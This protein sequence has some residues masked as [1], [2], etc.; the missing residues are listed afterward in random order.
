MDYKELDNFVKKSNSDYAGFEYLT[1]FFTLKLFDSVI[2]KDIYEQYLNSNFSIDSEKRNSLLELLEKP[3]VQDY[4]LSIGR[5]DLLII[6]RDY[7]SFYNIDKNL[8]KIVYY[9]VL[10]I[11]KVPSIYN[12]FSPFITGEF[13]IVSNQI[14]TLC[15]KLVNTKDKSIYVPFR[16]GLSVADYMNG[17]IY[18]EDLDKRMKIVELFMN[19]YEQKKIQ[20]HITNSLETPT[21]IRKNELIKF[22]TVLAFP[23]FSVKGRILEDDLF[24]RF[25]IP[26]KRTLD[27]ASFEHV[28][29]QTKN[30]AIVLMPVG[31]SFRAGSEEKFRKYL[32]ESNYLKALIQLPSSMHTGTSIETTL[33]V[34]DKKKENSNVLFFDLRNEKF[35]TKNGR[36]TI[37]RNI[38]EIVGLYSQF[39]DDENISI[40]DAIEIEKN[41]YNLS[42]D[43]YVLSKEAQEIKNKIS[44]YDLVKLKDIADVKKCQTVKE[45]VNFESI[46]EISP[47]DFS[48]AGYTYKAQ[49]QKRID[50]SSSPFKTYKLEPFDILLSAK[51]ILGKVA[52]VGENAKNILAS[53]AIQRIRLKNTNNIK[54]DAIVIYMYLK[55]NDGQELLDKLLKQGTAMPQISTNDLMSFLVPVLDEEHKSRIVE[56]FNLEI[57]KYEEINKIKKDIDL[58]NNSFFN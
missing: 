23:P 15:T 32:V 50:I 12:S 35:I 14:I 34:I 27:V 2:L 54:K 9:E 53:Q 1:C 25:K 57:I 55:S 51:G 22:D 5:Q 29:S 30:E 19:I 3:D 4:L 43:R 44:A 33:Y 18:C 36:Q 16:M 17:N 11:K 58:I 39:I 42:I 56:N 40:V 48:F 13:S 46:C 26:S 49:K 31:F 24:N 21:F 8:L 20:L 28:L 38:D 41:N 10:K 52:L 6:M 37:L 47:S 45:N 7:F